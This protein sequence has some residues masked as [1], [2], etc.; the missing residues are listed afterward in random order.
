MDSKQRKKRHS[1]D[2]T[3]SGGARQQ[4]GP[5]GAQNKSALVIGH[6]A[7]GISLLDGSKVVASDQFVPRIIVRED[8]EMEGTDSEH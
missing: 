6:G 8:I 3:N 5:N 2:N 7:R 1:V 4:V